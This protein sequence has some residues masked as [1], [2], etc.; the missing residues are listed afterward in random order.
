MFAGKAPGGG[1]RL[2]GQLRFLQGIRRRI[3]APFVSWTQ[4]PS[5][6]W[7][8]FSL[9][10]RPS[11]R[12][13]LMAVVSLWFLWSQLPFPS[14]VQFLQKRLPFLCVL[15]YAAFALL[16]SLSLIF[17]LVFKF[18]TR[19]RKATNMKEKRVQ[20]EGNG[21]AAA[22]PR[23]DLARPPLFRRQRRRPRP[24]TWPQ[25]ARSVRRQSAGTNGGADRAQD[26]RS[27]SVSGCWYRRRGGSRC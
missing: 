14:K 12:L 10:L 21:Q 17:L 13:L 20:R 8:L 9:S 11:L 7:S 1:E 5:L 19:K 24:A 27:R 4:F 15:S 16:L 22:P 25:S 2:S 23:T 6:L 26:C 3:P 18:E